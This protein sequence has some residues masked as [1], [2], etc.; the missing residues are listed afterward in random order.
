MAAT[1][2]PP[3]NDTE[4]VMKECIYSAKFLLN[5]QTREDLNRILSLM[6]PGRVY[7]YF[8]IIRRG[9]VLCCA[10]CASMI[11]HGKS[12]EAPATIKNIA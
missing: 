2:Q 3:K 8:C 5:V 4:Q 12:S 10:V 7:D 1:S 6:P 11:E 9:A